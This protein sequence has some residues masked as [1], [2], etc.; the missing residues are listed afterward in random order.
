MDRNG[1]EDYYYRRAKGY[2]ASPS[3]R[4]SVQY[5]RRDS[6]SPTE[7]NYRSNSHRN[8]NDRSL[9]LSPRYSP[10]SQSPSLPR[11]ASPET[12]RSLLYQKEPSVS[13]P[14]IRL[15]RPPIP[16]RPS[17]A[18]PQLP[19]DSSNLV[20]LYVPLPR[21]TT[22]HFLSSYFSSCL[23]LQIYN[24]ALRVDQSPS[25]GFFN[26]ER[27]VWEDEILNRRI[28]E[29]EQQA[30]QLFKD[31]EGKVWYLRPRL[32]V[33]P[34]F[35]EYGRGVGNH[36]SRLSVA[37]EEDQARSTEERKPE[38]G[39]DIDPVLVLVLVRG[40]GQGR[41]GRVLTPEAKGNEVENVG[42][43]RSVTGSMEEMKEI[44]EEGRGVETNVVAALAPLIDVPFL[45]QALQTDLIGSQQSLYNHY[46]ASTQYADLHGQN[47]SI[48]FNSHTER[49][50]FP[51]P[52]RTIASDQPSFYR[53]L[54]DFN[55]SQSLRPLPPTA[56]HPVSHQPSST[57]PWSNQN[58]EADSQ[59]YPP[60]HQ[61]SSHYDYRNRPGRVGGW[62]SNGWRTVD[63][64][65][66]ERE[67]L[68]RER[69]WKY[70]DEVNRDHRG[71][72]RG[73]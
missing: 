58:Y 66:L 29:I 51:S 1:Q 34:R 6:P 72:P 47:Q 64:D 7:S 65:E 23:N 57:Q 8:R 31:D 10:Y 15:P 33:N 2:K 53:G 35:D 30:T 11:S 50:D 71:P 73:R 12:S 70:W 17:L 60:P 19:L 38:G 3:P 44:L 62:S 52:S 43:T 42:G 20:R 36:H 28:S 18:S 61:D 41:G 67:R 27:I 9:S 63:R 68:E 32:A 26:V 4:T 54:I 59:Y 49:R 21:C 40:Q 45:M 56:S 69:E 48:P 5:R 13:P 22:S 39:N 24:L 25:Y 14:L 16:L 37:V 46:L 55:T